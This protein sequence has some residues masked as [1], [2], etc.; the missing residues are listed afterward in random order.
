MGFEIDNF[1]DAVDYVVSMIGSEFEQTLR[2]A[3]AIIDD[4]GQYSGPQASAAALKLSAQRYKIGLAAQFWKVRG[5]GSASNVDKMIKNALHLAYQAL[6]EVINTLKI[7]AKQ[8][9]SLAQGSRPNLTPLE[10]EGS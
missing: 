3:N 10:V 7:T 6:E 1:D 8:D 5:G 9:H 4:P 2:M